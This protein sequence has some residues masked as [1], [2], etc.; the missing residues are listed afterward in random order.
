VILID[1]FGPVILSALQKKGLVLHLIASFGGDY[2]PR[3][4]F[5]YPF[6]KIAGIKLSKMLFSNVPETEKKK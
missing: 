5:A 1:R 6:G 4:N 2:L 3:L